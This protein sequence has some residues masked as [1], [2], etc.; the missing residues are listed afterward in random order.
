MK[1]RWINIISDRR[2]NVL[3]MAAIGMILSA[4][5]VGGGIDISR[6]YR[7]KNRLQ[8][9]C[10]SAVL[11]GRRAVATS[12]LDTPAKT[13]ANAYFAT[14]FDNSSLETTSTSFVPSSDDNGQTDHRNADEDKCADDGPHFTAAGDAVGDR[15]GGSLLERPE[16]HDGADE[17]RTPE[18]RY[19]A[20]RVRAERPRGE[21]E[22]GVRDA[23]QYRRC[24]Q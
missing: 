2:G 24:R 18:G 4:L 17:D 1:I 8:S 19:P 13:Q 3:P 11:A 12:G 10:D 15:A 20:V 21:N 14:N 23:R 7:A 22:E 5:L 6:G 16:Q 9:A